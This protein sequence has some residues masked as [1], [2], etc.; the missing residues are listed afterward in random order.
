[1]SESQSTRRSF[2]VAG[3]LGAGGALF[4]RFLPEQLLAAGLEARKSA[5]SSEA[6]SV[7]SPEDAADVKAF[8]AQVFPTD[9]TPGANEA[10]VV[11][12]IDHVL[13]K[14]EPENQKEFRQCIQ[15][16][17]QASAE[18]IPGSTRFAKLSNEEQLQVMKKF[19]SVKRRRRSDLMGAVFGGEI[20]SF[21]MLR[22]YVIA[23]FLCDPDNGG[24][25]DMVGWQVIGFDG[26]AMHEPPF[27]YYDAELLK[28]GG[29]NK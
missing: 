23:G 5:S 16:L 19:E 3:A 1:M 10:N 26:M 7:F 21:E 12:F 11:Y 9:E 28:Q 17:N 27:G 24:N 13:D 15:H 29:E 8:A 25:K 22:S 6:F 4:S 2:L 14:V 20:N 18:L